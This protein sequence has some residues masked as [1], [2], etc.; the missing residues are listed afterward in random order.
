MMTIADIDKSIENFHLLVL[1][2][3]QNLKV[4]LDKKIQ[5]LQA[6][7]SNPNIT[8]K[9]SDFIKNEWLII[10]KFFKFTDRTNSF[11]ESSKNLFHILKNQYSEGINKGAAAKEFRK[12][13]E[14][15]HKMMDEMIE[16]ILYQNAELRRLKK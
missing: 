12:M 16:T 1:D 13:L 11:I 15:N 4:S 8:K 6:A 7:E 14:S 9:Q 10:E 2:D 5:Q 3:Y